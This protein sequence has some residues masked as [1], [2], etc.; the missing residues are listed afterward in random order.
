MDFNTATSRNIYNV[1]AKTSFMNFIII[2]I[3]I[4]TKLRQFPSFT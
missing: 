2:V 3:I 4:I 1:I